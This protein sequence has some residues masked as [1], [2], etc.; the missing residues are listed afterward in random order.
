MLSCR[1]EFHTVYFEE[2][3]DAD[4]N[5]FT[6]TAARAWVTD[7]TRDLS[8]V[9]ATIAAGVVSGSVPARGMASFV[10]EGTVG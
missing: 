1:G 5:R 7:N 6:A 10:V 8:E 9:P 4:G 3:Y 2:W